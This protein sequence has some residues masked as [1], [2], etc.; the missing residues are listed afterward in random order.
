[1]CGFALSRRF[2]Y[3]VVRIFE[4]SNIFPAL[5]FPR[6]DAAE[7]DTHFYVLSTSG[8]FLDTVCGDNGTDYTVGD[9][10]YNWYFIFSSDNYRSRRERG[11]PVELLNACSVLIESGRSPA[12][13]RAS[14]T[15]AIGQWI[16]YIQFIDLFGFFG[17]GEV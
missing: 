3:V 17:D 2:Q 1:M 9:D 12:G 13:D 15:L 5:H 7:C 4:G 6:T 14:G 8:I 16:W 11:R 10:L